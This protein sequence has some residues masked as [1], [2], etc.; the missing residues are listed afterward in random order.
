MAPT[1]RTGWRPR[2]LPVGGWTRASAAPHGSS[3]TSAPT[4][5]IWPSSCPANAS[6]PSRPVP[7]PSIPPGQLPP[8]RRSAG[9]PAASRCRC[10]PRTSPWP[11][12]A[13][14]TVCWPMSSSRRCRPA[15]RI[16]CGWSWTDR[17]NP[18]CSTRSSPNQCGSAARTAR[19][20]SGGARG[21]FRRIRHG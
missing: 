11:V 20:S 1:C 9:T 7:R 8:A 3:P 13:R 14:S 19:L 2:G 12:S 16:G 15:G 6:P 4:G 10:R 18:R 17:D 21:R 5:S